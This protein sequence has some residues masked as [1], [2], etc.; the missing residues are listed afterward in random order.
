MKLALRA[1]AASRLTVPGADDQDL[2]RALRHIAFSPTTKTADR[3]RAIE[4]LGRQSGLF[5]ET[6]GVVAPPIEDVK[7]KLG[8]LILRRL[9]S[10]R[11]PRPEPSPEPVQP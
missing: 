10:L 2:L 8:A 9:E 7:E 1:L 3:L 6:G 4:L 5:Q 11:P